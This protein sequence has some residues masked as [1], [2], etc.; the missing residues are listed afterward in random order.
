MTPQ[1]GAFDPANETNENVIDRNV[2]VFLSDSTH[3]TR[4]PDHCFLYTICCTGNCT[5]ALFAA[6]K[7]GGQGL[8]D[9]VVEN[10]IC[11]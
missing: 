2:G 9:G 4:I 6:W 10:R 3:P 1:R 11:C 8:R 7:L 5:P